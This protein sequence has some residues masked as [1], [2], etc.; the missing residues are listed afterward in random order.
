M[1]VN[2]MNKLDA[3]HNCYLFQIKMDFRQSNQNM[4]LFDCLLMCFRLQLGGVQGY[5]E[6]GGGGG[7]SLTAW[8][9]GAGH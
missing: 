5:T 2:Q 4:S 8:C 7:Q 9:R 3:Q 1:V 6:W